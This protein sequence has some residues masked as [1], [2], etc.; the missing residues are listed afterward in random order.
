MRTRM[1]IRSCPNRFD[2]LARGL[3][4]SVQKRGPRRG[5]HMPGPGSPAAVCGSESRESFLNEGL[6]LRFER[7]LEPSVPLDPAF[8]PG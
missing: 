4:W 6:P 1:R 5:V 2:A 8:G 7:M 3:P